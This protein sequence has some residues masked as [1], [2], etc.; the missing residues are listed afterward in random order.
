MTANWASPLVAQLNYGVLLP[1]CEIIYTI[2]KNWSPVGMGWYKSWD[3]SPET[4]KQAQLH[5]SVLLAMP[6]QC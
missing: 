6:Q 4:S 2:Q 5:L 1:D 3:L